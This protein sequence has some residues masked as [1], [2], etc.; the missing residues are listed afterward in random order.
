[1]CMATL[2][3]QTCVLANH[4]RCFNVDSDITITCMYMCVSYHVHVIVYIHL[5]M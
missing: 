1:M 5:Y 4:I 3:S 2:E